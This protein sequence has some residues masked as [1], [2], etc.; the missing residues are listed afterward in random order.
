MAFVNYI[1]PPWDQ[2]RPNHIPIPPI[3]R[4]NN[5]QIPLNMAWALTI[6]K[7][8]ALTLT[9]PTID[10][11]NNERQVFTFY[12]IKRNVKCTIVL[13]KHYAKMKDTSYVSLWKKEEAC[14]HSLYISHL[15]L[16]PSIIA[17]PFHQMKIP[18]L[19][20]NIIRVKL[21]H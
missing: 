12:N 14:F 13:L 19:I 20:A 18:M 11:G 2:S 3:N 1:G 6:H 10:I 15:K 4:S 17:P 7:S 5:K 8:Q 21:H 16:Q 9:R